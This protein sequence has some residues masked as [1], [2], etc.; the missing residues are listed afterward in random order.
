MGDRGYER[1]VPDQAGKHV[2]TGA[3]S[4]KDATRHLTGAG[5]GSR[6]VMTIRTPA[7]G[8]VAR[9]DILASTPAAIA[10]EQSWDL[11]STT[12][13][14]GF[15]RTNLQ[16][17]GPNSLGR[18]KPRRSAF[19]A[20]CLLP[21]QG[22]EHSEPSHRSTPRPAITPKPSATTTPASASVSPGR[23]P[24]TG[25]LNGPATPRPHHGSA[26]APNTSLA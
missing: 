1:D 21:S 23:P 11:L 3:N 15:T 26:P 9:A 25:P 16:S 4:G 8:E 14:P 7:K 19:E 6:A 24:R 5:A 2:V 13:H 18:D 10:A 12:A 20:V 22:V 17:S